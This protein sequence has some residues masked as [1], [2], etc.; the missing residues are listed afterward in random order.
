MFRLILRGV[1]PLPSLRTVSGNGYAPRYRM[2]RNSTTVLV[3][4]VD[5]GSGNRLLRALLPLKI[6]GRILESADATWWKLIWNPGLLASVP[7]L[8]AAW[9]LGGTASVLS[10]MVAVTAPAVGGC[11]PDRGGGH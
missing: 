4:G 1:R 7:A 10:L 2:L 5:E 8:V 11:W 9:G 3:N 6:H